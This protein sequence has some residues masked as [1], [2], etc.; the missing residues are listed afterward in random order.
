M[1]NDLLVQ[2]IIQ[3]IANEWIGKNPYTNQQQ[4]DHQSIDYLVSSFLFH[5]F[6]LK[7]IKGAVTKDL[8]QL[9]FPNKWFNKRLESASSKIA[10]QKNGKSYFRKSFLIS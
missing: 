3:C 5:R 8:S 7:K 1:R 6:L 2:I 10:F 9:R 4:K